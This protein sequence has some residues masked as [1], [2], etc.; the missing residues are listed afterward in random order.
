MLSLNGSH[1][2]LTLPEVHEVWLKKF[3]QGLAKLANEFKVQLVG[4]DTT[5]GP[6]SISI[7][8][9]GSVDPEKALRRDGCTEL[10]ILSM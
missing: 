5:K 10:A 3:S 9:H 2:A 8:V 4:G 7:Q 6:L 1:L